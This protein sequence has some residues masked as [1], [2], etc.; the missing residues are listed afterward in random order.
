M[1]HSVTGAEAIW[2][3]D[4]RTDGTSEYTYLQAK[5]LQSLG[6]PQ[7]FPPGDYKMELYIGDKLEQVGNFTIE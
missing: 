5:G 4:W 1:I 7:Y 3:G 6:W 2:R